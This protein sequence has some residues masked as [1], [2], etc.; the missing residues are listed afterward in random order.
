MQ[1]VSTASVEMVADM[2]VKGVKD[3]LLKT[4]ADSNVMYMENTNKAYKEVDADMRDD[5]VI[6]TYIEKNRDPMHTQVYR[7]KL[8]RDLVAKAIQKGYANKAD[9]FLMNVSD[10]SEN[11]V[12]NQMSMLLN[13]TDMEDEYIYGT[14]LYM[15]A[16][17]VKDESNKMTKAK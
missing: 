2:F 16:L 14:G 1:M 15:C 6:C 9:I 13:S 3:Y 17:H 10:M 8:S 4:P 5:E 11:F 7:F 12:V